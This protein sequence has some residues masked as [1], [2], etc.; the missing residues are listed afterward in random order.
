VSGAAALL[1]RLPPWVLVVG[2]GGVGKTTCAASLAIAAAERGTATLVLST[3]PA[4]A[5]GDVLGAALGADPVSVPG[6]PNLSAC[7]LD[8]AIERDRFLDRWREVLVTIIDRGTYLERDDVTSLVDGVLPGA[9]E[10]MALLRLADLAVDT[11]WQRIIV[12]TAP[13]GHT[14]RLL[15]LPHSFELLIALLDAMQDKHRFMVRALM[16]RYRTDD[17]D[18]FL[19]QMRARVASLTSLLTD[20][21]RCA[22]ALVT[23]AEPVVMAESERYARALSERGIAVGAVIMNAADSRDDAPDDAAQPEL[24]RVTPAAAWMRARR[25]AVALGA[26]GAREWGTRLIDAPA[27]SEEHEAREATTSG[28]ASASGSIHARASSASAISSAISLL[29]PL[30]ALTI[31]GGKGGVGKTTVACALALVAAE[32]SAASPVLL[33]STDPAPSLADALLQ[34]IGDD[35]TSVA[36]APGLMA[37]QADAS[38]A[39]ERL[40]ADYAGRID[41]F[42][43]AIAGR[44]LDTPHDRRILRELLALAPPGID[45]LYA[46]AALADAVAEGRFARVIVDPAPTGHLLRLLEMPAIALTWTHQL[47]RLM[48]RY[49]EL[50][51]LGDAAADVLALAHRIRA[52]AALLRDPARASLLVVTLDEP[53][54]R[55][56]TRR[57]VDSVTALG[58]AITGVI[59]NR[60]SPGAVPPGIP[61]PAAAPTAQLA[62]TETQPSPRGVTALREWAGSWRVND[63]G[64][65]AQSPKLS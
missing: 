64:V 5:L 43:D 17:A 58:V 33:V 6:I 13:T 15:D 61:L 53:L 22:A 51:T 2:K 62:A 28:S 27:P 59:W 7:Q 37:R 12:D 35:E 21:A 23:R 25:D 34:P 10:A 29:T 38:A 16:H 41:A 9:D 32:P 39:F 24:R 50:G 3:D 56:E 36:G 60:T 18:A 44:G 30:P 55:N 4:R 8:A 40:R 14:L 45:E 42:F 49:K 31:V 47:M 26:D 20:R 63:A 48:L 65:R 1:D 11:R 54:V 52:V 57:L 19:A 46:L